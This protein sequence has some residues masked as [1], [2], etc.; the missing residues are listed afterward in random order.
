MLGLAVISTGCYNKNVAGLETHYPPAPDPAQAKLAEAA[1]SVSRSLVSL[2]EIEQASLP[3]PKNYSPPDPATY[4][5]ANLVS[6]DWGGPVEPLVAQIAASS[7]YKIRV[8]GNPPAVPVMVFLS[9]K[10]V[11]LGNVLRDIGFQ[12][13]TKATVVVFPR[14]KVIELRYVKH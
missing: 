5:M 13:N 10:N 6:I 7:G 1:S 4:G 2:A 8:L 9:V 11:P 12:V 14:N 3:P